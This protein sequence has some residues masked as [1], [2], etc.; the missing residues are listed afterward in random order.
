VRYVGFGTQG[1][2]SRS[3]PRRRCAGLVGV[4]VQQGTSRGMSASYGA[5]EPEVFMHTD[6][7]DYDDYNMFQ[8]RD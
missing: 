6:Y 1:T 7:D 5:D 8:G 4:Q 3:V 2:L